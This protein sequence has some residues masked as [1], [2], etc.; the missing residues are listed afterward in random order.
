MV[1]V[2]KHLV[3]L[4]TDNRASLI[5]FSLFCFGFFYTCA[6]SLCISRVLSPPGSLGQINAI[7]LLNDTAACLSSSLFFFMY[8]VWRA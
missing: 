1:P 7:K 2:G 5:H 6:L 8:A 4:K 3:A